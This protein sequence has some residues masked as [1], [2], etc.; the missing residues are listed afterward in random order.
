MSSASC[1]LLLLLL[2]LVIGTPCSVLVHIPQ[3]KLC[4]RLDYVVYVVE[5]LPPVLPPYRRSFGFCGSSEQDVVGLNHTVSSIMPPFPR[6]C[7]VR[8]DFSG[9]LATYVHQKICMRMCNETWGE[10]AE[11]L[12]AV[13]F[14]SKT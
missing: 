4:R 7:C 10:G 6:P 13:L 12:L 14:F 3:P 11:R 2:L 1:V 5:N 8:V 9:W